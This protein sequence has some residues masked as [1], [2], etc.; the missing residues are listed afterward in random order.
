MMP[1]TA[2]RMVSSRQR[3]YML[4][5]LVSSREILI[6]RNSSMMYFTRVASTVTTSICINFINPILNKI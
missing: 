5:I 2:A 4:M 6:K 1:C 3:D